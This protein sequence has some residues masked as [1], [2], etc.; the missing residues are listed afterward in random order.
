MSFICFCCLA[1]ILSSYGLHADFWYLVLMLI[2][3]SMPHETSVFL[4]SDVAST[5]GPGVKEYLQRP[6]I[7]QLLQDGHSTGDETIMETCNWANAVVQQ[8]LQAS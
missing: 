4:R 6:S 2:F 1:F 8:A 3:T 7:A 5:V